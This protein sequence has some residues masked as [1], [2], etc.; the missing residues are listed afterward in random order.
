MDSV[1]VGGLDRLSTCAVLVSEQ[2]IHPYFCSGLP[3]HTDILKQVLPCHVLQP[4]AK[5]EGTPV[6]GGWH[7][8]VI[9][10]GKRI[11]LVQPYEAS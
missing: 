2:D 9:I 8:Y 7:T 4:I 11:C 6:L 5:D 1:N 10:T 3:E